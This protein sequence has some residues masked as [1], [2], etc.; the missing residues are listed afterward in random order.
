MKIF[1]EI[2]GPKVPL[3][4]PEASPMHTGMRDLHTAPTLAA[5]AHGTRD[6]PPINSNDR[7]YNPQSQP[8]LAPRNKWKTALPT[9][10]THRH[11]G[12]RKEEKL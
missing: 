11:H 7:S 6:G 12:I 9:E 4:V 1:V 8:G 10:T 5:L 2:R 3:Y